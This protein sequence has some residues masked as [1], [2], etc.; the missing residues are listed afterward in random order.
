MLGRKSRT[1]HKKEFFMRSRGHAL[2]TWVL[3]ALFLLGAVAVVA[4]DE[5]PT[6]VFEAYHRLIFTCKS[7]S[8]LEPY[9]STKILSKR[10]GGKNAQMIFDQFKLMMPRSIRVTGEKIDGAR[11]TV[12]AESLT[13]DPVTKAMSPGTKSRT[14]G[15][16][17]MVK[18]DGH[19]KVDEEQWSTY[20]GDAQPP[21]M[22]TGA[23]SWCASAAK[24]DFPSKPAAGQL[25]GQA[26]K[27]ASAEYSSFMKSLTL[28]DS[29]DMFADRRVQI[30][31]GVDD[32]NVAGKQFLVTTNSDSFHSP[33]VQIGWK[34]VAKENPSQMYS[35]SDGYGMRLQFGTPQKGLLPGYIVLRLPDKS[36]EEGYFYAKQK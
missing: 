6:S 15:K 7:I 34:R 1:I 8:E 11:A 23:A 21:Q 16:I 36:F 2:T 20:V 25:H 24:T 30:W 14:L 9:E 29:T 19:W 5:T 31:L 3:P 17:I 26:F 28:T 33:N 27:V 32:P 22:A 4:A 10:P 35:A 18:E 13:G 12:S